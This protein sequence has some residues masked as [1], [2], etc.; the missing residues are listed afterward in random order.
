LPIV[1]GEPRGDSPKVDLLPSVVGAAAGL[2]LGWA[3]AGYQHLLY[4]Q[5]EYRANPARGRRLLAHRLFLAA[6]MAATGGLALRPGHYDAGPALLS[7]GFAW[8]LCVLSSTDL[9]RRIIPNRLTYPAVAIAVLLAWAWPD[10]SL[11]SSLV[12]GAV[13]FLAGVALFA[14][15]VLVARAGAFGLGDVK[16]MLLAGLLTGWPGI[17]TALLIGLCAA[18][19]PALILTL[20]GRGRTYFAYGPYLALGALVVMLFPH[21]FT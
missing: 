3:F 12:G 4:R 13:G 9:E 16:L 18:G 2:G 15:G 6:S 17:F 19:V 21:T 14:A 10:R 20:T 8:V 5:P 7:L 1:G 11:A